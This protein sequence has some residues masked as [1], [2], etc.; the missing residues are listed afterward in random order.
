MRKFLVVAAILAGTGAAQAQN[1]VMYITKDN[2]GGTPFIVAVQNGAIINQADVG[3]YTGGQGPGG[4]AVWGDVR[5]VSQFGGGGGLYDLGLNDQSTPYGALP[6]TDSYDG[7]SDGKYNY[8]TDFATGDVYR[9]DRDYANAI[10]LYNNGDG[11]TIGI[12]YNP[13]TGHLYT[14]SQATGNIYVHDTSGGFITTIPTA[15]GGENWRGLAFDPSDQTL[16]LTRHDPVDDTLRQLDLNGGILQTIT[17]PGLSALVGGS[18]GA[19]F[20]LVP[21]P[22]AAALL[23]IGGLVATR[24]RR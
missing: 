6:F 5:F 3:A 18:L 1:G 4:I 10:R 17:V 14:H 8:I 9:A 2:R 24:R 21:A 20:N 22:G 13:F 19:E 16:W 15:F 23:G 12:T 7:T 11:S